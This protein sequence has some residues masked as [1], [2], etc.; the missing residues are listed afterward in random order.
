MSK[1]YDNIIKEVLQNNK[2]LIN[3]GSILKEYLF[4]QKDIE[5]IKGSIQAINT[6]IDYLIE[7][8]NSLSI[9]VLDEEDFDE[10]QE[11]EDIEDYGGDNP[12][13]TGHDS[14]LDDEDEDEENYG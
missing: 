10:D 14:W 6:K 3:N 5:L 4:V 1:D 2:D 12:W 11:N 8:M 7:I 9:M 13:D